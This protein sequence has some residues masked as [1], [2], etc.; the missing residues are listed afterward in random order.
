MT[1]VALIAQSVE[2]L[3][4]NEKVVS[5]SLISSSNP[6]QI[7]LTG[8]FLFPLNGKLTEMNGVLSGY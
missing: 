8:I 4:R 1:P 3:T 7:R 2:H 5:S 6:R